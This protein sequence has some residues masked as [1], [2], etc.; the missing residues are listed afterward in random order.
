MEYENLCSQILKI[1][2]KIRFVAVFNSWSEKKAEK[3]QDGLSVHLP[4]RITQEAVNQALFRWE[5][6]KKMSEWIGKPKYAMAEYEKTK[7]LTFYL[8]ENDILL[9]S[10]ETAAD[11]N[12]I[13]NQIQQ[14]LEKTQIEYV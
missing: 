3:I 1:D 10:T 13:I 12:F 4:E 6:R 11:H 9:V 14:F 2:S 8:N 7:R 5:S